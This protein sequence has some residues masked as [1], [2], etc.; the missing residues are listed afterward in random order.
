MSR[1]TKAMT[2]R[3]E[4]APKIIKLMHY[5]PAI[6]KAFWSDC[7]IPGP[8]TEFRF[9]PPR[10]WRFDFAWVLADGH[11]GTAGAEQICSEKLSE[12]CGSVANHLGGV[13]LE[14]QGGIFTRGRHTR[15]AALL[16]EYDKLNMAAALGWRVL[17]CPPQQLLTLKLARQLKNAL[18]FST[19]FATET[20]RH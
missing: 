18:N 4:R 7:G 10:Q 9:A 6:V 3:F 16:K 1:R 17:F 15:G 11:H 13:A 8:L 2:C 12:P 14:V 5:N 19:D 20:P